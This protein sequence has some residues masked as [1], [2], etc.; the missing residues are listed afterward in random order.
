MF[1]VP[2]ITGRR[3]RDVFL[4]ETKCILTI[5]IAH[6]IITS[7]GA[8]ETWN[9]LLEGIPGIDESLDKKTAPATQPP[10]LTTEPSLMPPMPPNF[11]EKLSDVV[12]NEIAEQLGKNAYRTITELPQYQKARAEQDKQLAEDPNTEEASFTIN[13]TER[14]HTKITRNPQQGFFHISVQYRLVDTSLSDA[15]LK[16]KEDAFGRRIWQEEYTITTAEVGSNLRDLSD[17][18]FMH[19]HPEISTSNL[20]YISNNSV[21]KQRIQSG[22]FRLAKHL[23]NA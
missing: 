8:K 16:S 5:Y 13:R 7:M 14:Y 23:P 2:G 9:K 12:R 6:I 11:P 21:A 15:A 4:W 18:T 20:E 10:K 1:S 3:Q 17:F 19:P 22:T